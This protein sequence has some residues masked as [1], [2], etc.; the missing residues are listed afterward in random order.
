MAQRTEIQ[1]RTLPA[2]TYY[3][4]DP[5]YAFKDDHLW[6]ALLDSAW[7]GGLVEADADGRSFTSSSTAYGDGLYRDQHGNEYPVDAGMIGV[8]L[9]DHADEDYVH[10]MVIHEF[11]RPFTVA[12]NDG[13]ITIG[14]IVIETGDDDSDDW[15]YEDD[16]DDEDEDED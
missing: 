9:V 8:V 5:C 1:S 13:T 4:G 6:M 7:K 10:G 11:D 15:Y 3:V 12:Y 16:E 14:T 2:G